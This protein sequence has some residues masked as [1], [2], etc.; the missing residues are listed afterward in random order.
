MDK[1]K[2]VWYYLIPIFLILRIG[3]FTTNKLS[4]KSDIIEVKTKIISSRGRIE[5]K[6]GKYPLNREYV[7]VN[8]L[9]DGDYILKGKIIAEKYSEYTL[10]VLEFQYIEEKFLKKLLRK[11]VEKINANSTYAQKNIHMSVITGDR[12]GLADK[13]KKS[14]SK[15][16]ISHILAISGLHI[17]I[18]IVIFNWI[19]LKLKIFKIQRNILILIV[20]NLYYLSINISP[21]VTRAYIMGTIFLLGNI[22]SEN[23]SMKKSFSIALVINL[24]IFPNSFK[25]V[26]FILSYGAVLGIILITPYLF[27]IQNYFKDKLG[28]YWLKLLNYIL[29]T[30][31]LQLF[32][33]PIL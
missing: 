8:K 4:E 1:L 22:F 5:K 28:K 32:L 30:F 3:Y 21:S 24:A 31:F 6:D 20:L 9:K 19:F 15:A 7:R 10:K 18:L 26:S 25:E 27:K 16:G 29:F 23:S 33:S 13:V 2:N 11:R 14:F 12:S 17:G